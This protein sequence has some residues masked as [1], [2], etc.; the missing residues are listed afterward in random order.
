ME[1]LFDI[2]DTFIALLP[3]FSCISHRKVCDIGIRKTRQR[4]SKK[5]SARS[6]IS[7]RTSKTS[8]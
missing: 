6:Q 7:F 3:E 5:R 8:K 4:K 2:V 1:H